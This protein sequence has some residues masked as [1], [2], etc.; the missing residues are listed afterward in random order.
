MTTTTPTST[1]N[2]PLLPLDDEVVLPGMVVPLDLQRRA[3]CGP[4]SRPPRPP[5]AE[6]APVLLVP[7]ID[8][9]YAAV[10][11]VAVVEQVGRLPGGDPGAVIRGVARVRIGAGTTGPGAA[12]WVE[13]TRSTAVGP[14]ARGARG[15]G[16][17]VQG[18][19]HPLAAASAAPGRSSTGVQQIDDPSA[20]ADN[21]GYSAFLTTEQKVQLLETAD[22]VDRL[23]L[24]IGRAREHL[25]EQDV[26]ETIRKDVQE[27]M[28]KQQREFLLRQQLDAV[29]KELARAQRRAATATRPTTTGPASRPPTCRRRSARPRSRRSTSWSAPPTS[30]PRA[31]GSAP[32][33]TPSSNC[34]GT[35]APRTSTTSPGARAVLDADHAGLD[36]VKERITEYLAVRKR[37]ADRG[38][39]RRRRPARRRGAGA[40][41]PARG[42]QDLARR[43]RRARDGPQVRPGRARRRP[44]RGRD[45]RPPAH[46]RRRAA[47]P[48]RPGR[49]RRPGR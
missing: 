47:R 43:V 34:P 1:Q 17:G 6:R 41:R 24:A 18:A 38:L 8:G 30:R 39:G 13:A 16:Q 27:G 14:P 12:L 5:A 19:G 21:S 20:L 15:A 36:D 44:G 48:D 11:T 10:G 46:V 26:A 9:Q 35:S 22:P 33:S 32:G 23:E 49:S 29:R 37:R 42:R 4:P 25:A 7:R 2:L 3:K 28:D 31:A 40:R 45:P